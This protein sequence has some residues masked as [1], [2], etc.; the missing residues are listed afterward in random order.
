MAKQCCESKNHEEPTVD[1]A[2][3][4]ELVNNMLKPPGAGWYALFFT[5]VVAVIWGGSCFAKQIMEGLHVAGI[6]H[7]IG[8]GVYITNF[9]FWVGIAHSGTLI[10]A[11]LFLFRA[12]FRMP[13]YRL[14]EAMT[15]FAVLTAGLFPLIHVGRPW[16]AY[17]LLP[18]PNERALWP[19]FRSPLLWDVFAVSTYL[20]VSTTFFIVGLIPD[21][22]SVRDKAKSSFRKMLYTVT[23]LGWTGSNSQWK[24]YMSAYLFF[25]GLATPLVVSVHSVV[26]WDFAVGLVPGWHATIFPPYFV[27]GAIFS[28]VGMVL[29][30]IIPLRKVFHLEEIITPF[31]FE[32]M[33]KLILLTSGIVSYA[34][35]TEFYVAW[36]SNN[37]F[38]RFQFWFRPFGDFKLAF[39]G[40]FTC[41]CIIPL[42][43][44][45]KKLRSNIAYLF[46][47]SIFI[48][49]GMWLERF[50]IIF[51]SLAREFIP[52]AWGGYNFSWVEVGITVGAFGWFGMY[53]CLFI[54]FFPAVSITEIKELLPPPVRKKLPVG[55]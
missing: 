9:V 52:A 54:K 11:V 15:V 16:F 42:T 10:S 8:W 37:L 31:H 46:I 2:R 21:I 6:N 44:W 43:L 25:A 53:M 39:W 3:V 35:A 49:I 23:S 14:A 17:W 32:G 34:Y 20:T 26:S 40:M 47:V 12:K 18:Y 51:T 5:C 45:F 28:G 22:A 7:P 29:T 41:N 13:I 50:N 36:F 27:A 1:Y 48:N 33:V 38:E 55:H 19:N 30:L 4:T 24:H